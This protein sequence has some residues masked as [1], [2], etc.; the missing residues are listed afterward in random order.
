MDYGHRQADKMLKD[1][2]KK[3]EAEYRKAAVEAE[4]SMNKYL[5]QYAEN[6]AK[7]A[8][9]VKSGEITKRDYTSWRKKQMLIGG[10]WKAQRDEL[11]NIYMNADKVAAQMIQEHK[12][13]VYALNFNY[14]TYEIEK[15][16]NIDTAFSLYNKE[17]VAR[18]V[19]GDPKLLPPVGKTTSEKIRRGEL[20][21]WNQQQ[22]QSVMT[23]GLLQGESVQKISKR[24]ATTVGERNA[25]SH[26]RAARTMTTSA[27]NAGRINSFKRAEDM[28]I[29]V[30]KQWLAV[31]DG[32]TRRSHRH[33]DGMA[34]PLDEEF[35]PNLMYPADPEAPPEEVYNCRCT[36]VASFKGLETDFS[37]EFEPVGF[38]SYEEWVEGH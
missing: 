16:A 14:G 5:A 2:E 35:A 34:I 31:H 26:Y 38:D 33:F 25:Y 4:K 7:M 27:E 9:L 37:K 3:I 30:K 1:L 18:L 15:G 19:K 17:A 28:G 22:I 36:L 12:Y 8:A 13:E 11:T 29:E 6:D 21:R 23:Q 32:R 10:K 24:L 20:K